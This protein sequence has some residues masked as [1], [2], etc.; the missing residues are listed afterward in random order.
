MIVTMSNILRLRLHRKQFFDLCLQVIDIIS[1]LLISHKRC[2]KDQ[3]Q[4]RVFSKAEEYSRKLVITILETS[5]CSSWCFL[6]NTIFL[7]VIQS[8]VWLLRRTMTY[9]DA[10]SPHCRQESIMF[11]IVPLLCRYSIHIIILYYNLLISNI[12]PI[13][14][15]TGSRNYFGHLVL[16]PYCWI[17]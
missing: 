11:I 8:Q 16:L 12:I 1:G 9:Y 6:A 3:D 2:R 14:I 10:H 7:D 15:N 17:S 5:S 4:N 13:N